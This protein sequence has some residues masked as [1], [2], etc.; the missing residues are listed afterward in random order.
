[1]WGKRA[2]TTE[3]VINK[4]REAGGEPWWIRTTDSLIKSQRGA[5]LKLNW[6]NNPVSTP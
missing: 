5:F 4:L 2:F 3:Q 6:S 1:M